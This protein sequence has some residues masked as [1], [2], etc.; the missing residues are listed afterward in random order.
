M[1]VSPFPSNITTG[2]PSIPDHPEHDERLLSQSID[3]IHALSEKMNSIVFLHG[4][5]CTSN[6]FC[7]VRDVINH[8][9]SVVDD[10]CRT[11]VNCRRDYQY[12][13]Y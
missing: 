13:T 5:G 11:N 10:L 1:I 3:T 4:N 2:V 6:I 12:S 8:F 9:L 7:A